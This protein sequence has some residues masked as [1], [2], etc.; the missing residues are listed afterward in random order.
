MKYWYSLLTGLLCTCVPA[1]AA[2]YDWT[3]KPLKEVKLETVAFRGWTPEISEPLEGT[4]VLI[5]GRHGDGRGM[6]DNA[7]WQA[8]ATELKFAILACQFTN[9]DPGLY[10]GDDRGEVA[11]AINEAVEHLAKES[12]QAALAK[13]PL[14]FWGTSA[15]SNVSSRYCK[16]FPD[17][18][19][20][21]ASSKGTWGRAGT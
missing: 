14:A 1:L 10:Q 17:R 13:G 12:N 4:L 2:T 7:R 18:V 6:A 15:G 16:H 5:P 19:A 8:L 3:A 21:F 11:E 20:A 9:G